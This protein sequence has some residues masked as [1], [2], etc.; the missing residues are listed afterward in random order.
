MYSVVSEL[1]KESLLLYNRLQLIVYDSNYVESLD[2]P[3]G[4][5]VV[6]NERCGLWYVRNH[7]TSSYFKLT[8]GH[9]NQWKFSQRRLNLHL[10]DTFRQHAG[11][12][13]VDA[14]RKG[15]LMPDAVSKTI[16]I[17]IAVMNCLNPHVGYDPS[18]ERLLV[19]LAEMSGT[20]HLQ[21]AARIPEFVSEAQRLRLVDPAVFDGMTKPLYPI[22][23]YP[24]KAV[25]KVPEGVYPIYL[26]TASKRVTATRRVTVNE[27]SWYYIQ[28]SGDDHELWAHR[29]PFLSPRVFWEDIYPEM[30]TETGFLGESSEDEFV[31]MITWIHERRQKGRQPTA[32][33]LKEL[34]GTHISFGKL[35]DNVDYASL[36]LAQIVNLSSHLVTNVPEKPRY[37]IYN[38]PLDDGK[39]G[40]KQ[41]REL[42]PTLV[43]QISPEAPLVIFCGLGKD[44]GVGLVLVML[45]THYNLEWERL[46]PAR[47]TK[48]LIKQHLSK[49]QGVNPL[50]NTLQSVNTYLM[51]APR[52]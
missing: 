26:I 42:L 34:E 52:K 10:F 18:D 20:L 27:S 31:E 14:T 40:S 4:V 13:I 16:P 33:S 41:L 1:R 2:L 25:E 32:T 7:T 47:P 36:P 38:H 43:P 37:P 3:A 15:K 6:P 29:V 46:E 44:L 19:T 51:S 23:V 39:R 21:M 22:W 9:D 48:E 49:I 30:A 50:R 8:D 12:A 35:E 45:C 17:W 28:G 11:V 24:G 5:A